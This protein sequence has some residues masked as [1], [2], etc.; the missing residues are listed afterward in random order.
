MYQQNNIY[1]CQAAFILL[2]IA[3]VDLFC[4]H[5]NFAVISCYMSVS[6]CL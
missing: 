1:I 4:D 3:A 6:V 5:N 2:Y